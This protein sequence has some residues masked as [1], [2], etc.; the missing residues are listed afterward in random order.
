MT[1]E[2]GTSTLEQARAHARAQAAAATGAG[3]TVPPTAATDLPGHVDPDVVIW[4]EVIDGGGYASRVLP[5]GTVVRITDVDGD[6]CVQLLAH[7][8]AN[9]AERLNVADTVKVQWQAYL[10]RGSLLLSDMG[11][12]L[13]TLIDDTSTRHDCLC[14][15]SNRRTND[16][17]YGDGSV[18]GASPNGRDLLALAA[19]K[20]DLGRV[21]LPPPM[22]LFKGVPVAGDGALGFDGEPRPGAYVELRAEVDVLLLLALTPH[23]LDPRDGYTVSPIRCTAWRASRPEND[24]WRSSTPERARAFENTDELLRGVVR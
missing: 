19:A 7:V 13:L 23:P 22:N 11:R 3:P 8:V 1:D 20:H 5:R 6:A 12:V 17:R 2:P 21:D 4:D 24:P 16:A 9:P 18:W 10:G 15:S 14:G